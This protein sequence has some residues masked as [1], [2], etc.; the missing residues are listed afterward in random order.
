[1]YIFGIQIS[2]EESVWIGLRQDYCG[3][4]YVWMWLDGLLVDE[5]SWKYGL[6]YRMSL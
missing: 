5:V 6:L 2:K 4:K 3:N 1:M